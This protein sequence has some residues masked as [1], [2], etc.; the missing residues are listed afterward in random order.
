MPA[1]SNSVGNNVKKIRMVILGILLIK[2]FKIELQEKYENIYKD[3]NI[4]LNKDHSGSGIGSY[5]S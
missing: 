2:T 4:L 3:K 5:S 1:C